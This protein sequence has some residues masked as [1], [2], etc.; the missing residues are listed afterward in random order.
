MGKLTTVTLETDGLRDFVRLPT[1]ER[2]ILG[3]MSVLKLVSALV[4]DRR[5]QRHALE[6]FNGDGVAIVA[7]DVDRML[8]LLAPRPIRR[9][10]H[11]FSFIPALKQTPSTSMEGN[12][13]SN[14]KHLLD[15]KLSHIENTIRAMS[16]RVASGEDV[17][18]KWAHNLREAAVKLPDFGDQSKNDAFS[19]MGAPKVDT[20]EDPGAW[21]PPT[22][23][24]HPL[25]KSAAVLAANSDL[26]EDILTK[27]A[28]TSDKVNALKTAGRPFNASRA[29]ADLHKIAAEVHTILSNVD[30]AEGWVGD[31]L[32][33]L[34][35]RA[36][37][38]HSLFAAA[39]S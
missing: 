14:A 36:E 23:I 3:T 2:Y 11:G 21:T 4:P 10:N 32:A 5:S 25:G 15:Q 19:D 30:M 33:A 20:I 8:E 1:G 17:P 12:I 29:Q 9:A 26:A 6:R 27:V 38:I 22:N 37:H 28:E 13:M 16:A 24:T 7:L 18:S 34:A 39:R 31:D 35:K